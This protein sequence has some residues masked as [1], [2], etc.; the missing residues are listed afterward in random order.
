MLEVG[1]MIHSHKQLRPEAIRVIMNRA[2]SYRH[3]VMGETH[4]PPCEFPLAAHEYDQL[5]M[6]YTHVGLVNTVP[7]QIQL[8]GMTCIR[9]MSRQ[10]EIQYDSEDTHMEA[11]EHAVNAAIQ[12]AQARRGV[13]L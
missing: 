8:Y 2:E 1:G 13:R 6:W 9:E 11:W 4:E 10:T 7:P 3:R 12:D 5:L